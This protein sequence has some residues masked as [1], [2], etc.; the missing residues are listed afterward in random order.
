MRTGSNCPGLALE[1]RTASPV[2]PWLKSAS[3]LSRVRVAAITSGMRRPSIGR[4]PTCSFTQCCVTFPVATPP[5]SMR[6]SKNSST[7]MP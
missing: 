5:P 2:S 4:L 6:N 7:L 3:A 1:A